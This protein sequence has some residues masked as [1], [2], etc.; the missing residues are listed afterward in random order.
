MIRAD[1]HGSACR[2]VS[3]RFAAAVKPQGGSLQ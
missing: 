3:R 2:S 1:V